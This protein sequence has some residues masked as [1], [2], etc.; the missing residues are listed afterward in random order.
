L[1]FFK[2]GYDLI[3]LLERDFVFGSFVPR[4]VPIHAHSDEEKETDNEEYL[5]SFLVHSLEPDL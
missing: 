5:R 1:S 3:S 2:L 4:V